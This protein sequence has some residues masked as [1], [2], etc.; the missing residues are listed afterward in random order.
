MPASRPRRRAFTLIELLVVISIIALLVAIL[1]PALSSARDAARSI[2]CLSMLRQIGIARSVYANDHK[3]W[4]VPAMAWNAGGI[5][6][7]NGGGPTLKSPWYNIYDFRVALTMER[8]TGAGSRWKTMPREY[9]CPAAVSAYTTDGGSGFYDMRR[10]YAPNIQADNNTLLKIGNGDVAGWA[11][12]GL[13][14][15][16][17]RDTEIL[18]ASAKMAMADTLNASGLTKQ[19]S[20]TYVNEDTLAGPN[21]TAYRHPQETVNLLFFDGHGE[22]GARD[23]VAVSP[24]FGADNPLWDITNNFERNP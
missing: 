23:E 17:F 15:A 9:V 7:N 12:K 4:D 10:V 8:D 3:G 11:A 18:E 2:S 20:D 24:P 6:V 13:D 5:D 22:N 1:L 21:K 14:F 19:H 16:A